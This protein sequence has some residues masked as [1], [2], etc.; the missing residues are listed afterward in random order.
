M[1][2]AGAALTLA[3]AY[4]Q[5][6]VY[7]LSDPSVQVVGED[8]HIKTRYE[9]TLVDIAR[10]Y[11]LGYEEITRANPGV[12][13]WLPGE[14]T[15]IVIPGRRILP[16]GPHTG[17]I[18]NL[19]EHRLYYFPKP[20]R[21]AKPV[22][23]TYPVSIGKMDWKTPLGETRI[24]SKQKNPF[25]YPPESVRKEHAANGDPI[26]AIVKPGPDNPLGAFAMRLA[27]HPGDYLI[28]GTNNPLA[29]G[30]P[31][32]HGCIRMY[33]ED[34]AAFFPSV[35]VGTSVRLVNDPVK[36]A[37]VDGELLLE[38]HPPVDAEGQTV[39]PV[40]AEF[41]QLLD[42]ALGSSTAAIHWDYAIQTLQAATG[43]PVTVG[44]EAVNDAAAP[45]TPTAAPPPGAPAVS[46]ETAAPASEAPAAPASPPA[47]DP[48]NSASGS[49]NSASAPLPT[50]SR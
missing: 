40:L 14:G 10:R 46:S 18:V 8:L 25:W 30:M 29:V 1:L 37:Y 49:A 24:I 27:I 23:V 33:P 3:A 43:I 4:A 47:S 12:D 36:V 28:H 16:P 39:E 22:V 7:D 38:V 15:E 42:L 31:V 11:S 2:L 5:A 32:T 34:I 44:L 9:D 45:A 41:E 17:I 35:P 26:P 6:T 20:R 50:A 13:P 19:P 21:G 48:A